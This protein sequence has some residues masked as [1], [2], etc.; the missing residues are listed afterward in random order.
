MEQITGRV[1]KLGDNIDTDVIY[2]GKYLP[3]TDAK[4]SPLPWWERVRVRG[5]QV[6]MWQIFWAFP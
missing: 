1:W 2:P 6:K 5:N 4:L 3:I